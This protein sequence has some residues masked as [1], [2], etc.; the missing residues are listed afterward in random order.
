MCGEIDESVIG[1]ATSIPCGA[2]RCSASVLGVGDRATSRIIQDLW[3]H[4][5]SEH[6]R[7]VPAQ[8]NHVEILELFD[9]T[10]SFPWCWPKIDGKL[11]EW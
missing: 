10:I 8:C 5:S 9:E 7:D 4:T 3:S 1:L 2:H 11:M 6:A